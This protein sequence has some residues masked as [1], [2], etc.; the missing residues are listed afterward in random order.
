MSDND[1]LG[2]VIRDFYNKPA[3]FEYVGTPTNMIRYP[4]VGTPTN[5][6][7]YPLEGLSL[8]IRARVREFVKEIERNWYEEARVSGICHTFFIEVFQDLV[9]EKYGLTM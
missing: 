6:I 4:Y 9:K 3:I 1:G 7:R 8:G 5:M 2:F